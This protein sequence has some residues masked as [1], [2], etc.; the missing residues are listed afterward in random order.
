MSINIFHSWFLLVTIALGIFVNFC[1]FTLKR[2]DLAIWVVILWLFCFVLE[3]YHQNREFE[4]WKR[5][6]FG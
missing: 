3:S 2:V 4:N 6:V 5:R 1:L